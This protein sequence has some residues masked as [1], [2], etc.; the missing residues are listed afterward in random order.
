VSWIGISDHSGEGIEM[1]EKKDVLALRHDDYELE[2]CPKGGGCITGF[3]Y[4]GI[5]IMRPASEAYFQHLEP[6][7]AGSFPLV[8]YSNRIADG[9]F[10]YDGRDYQLPLNMPPEPH[11]IHGDGWQAPWSVEMQETNRAILVHE[12]K[13]GPI[14]HRSR[15]IVDLDETGV[16]VR[17]ELTNTSDHALPFGIGHHPF[18][19]RTEGLT[20]KAA[21]SEVWLSDDRKIPEKKIPLPHDWDFNTPKRLAALDLDNCFSG[22]GG[23]AVMA[24]PETGLRLTLTA[25]PIFG[26]L[27]VFVPP[28][29]DF[30]CVEPVSNVNN[31]VNQL[32][33]GRKDTGLVVL[34]P[35]EP[36]SG[37]LHFAAAL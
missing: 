28:G 14:L 20:L 8:P 32:N 23:K 17:L 31:A 6:R 16:T 21:V 37:S 4:Q 10:T 12:A 26:H 9:R 27:V 33:E 35:G 36:L 5:D 24:W 11:A 13:D 1:T 7:Q 2:L 15:Q 29:K 3:R 19:P 18:F 22:F 34:E 30:V 25:D